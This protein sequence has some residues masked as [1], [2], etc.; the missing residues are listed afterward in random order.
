[1]TWKYHN[2]K[3]EYEE[4]LDDL[5]WPWAGH[6]I[7]AYDLVSN[8]KPQRIVELG[9]HYGTSLWSFSQAVKDHNMDT[10]IN[11][12]DTWKGEKHAGFYG[13]EVFKTV[14]DI[15][16]KYY[17]GL[18]I[19]LVRK[20]FD[21]A[22]ALFKDSSVDVLHIDGL[23]TYEAVKQ[24]FDSWLP[25]LKK[26]GIVILHD[27]KVVEKDFGVYKFWQELKERYTTAEFHHSYGLGIVFLEPN[28]I[29]DI[30]KTEEEL[31]IHYSYIHETK[32]SQAIQA[33]D[34][35]INN[36]K[37]ENKKNG[38]IFCL[39]KKIISFLFRATRKVFLFIKSVLK[40][41]IQNV[42]K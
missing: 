31:Q 24:D 40:L 2:P 36:L 37:L 33:K 30:G 5:S 18:K 28:F 19:N 29:R 14:N 41:S 26:E 17:F 42:F 23:H 6:K 21:E 12:I 1:M 10:E 25:K 11:A 22:R 13:E 15:K 35:I 32:R 39:L 4:K 38:M 20:K 34:K 16:N 3:L 8:L 9:T 27:I 7:F